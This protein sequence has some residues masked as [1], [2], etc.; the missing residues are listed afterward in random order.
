MLLLSDL[1]TLFLLQGAAAVGSNGCS[2]C[3]MRALVVK[4]LPSS[5]TAMCFALI[6]VLAG[7]V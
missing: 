2:V 3:D 7:E 4:P 5:R 1:L 6:R